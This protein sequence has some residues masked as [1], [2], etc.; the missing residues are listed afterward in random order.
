M[1]IL[2]LV[3][4]PHVHVTPITYYKFIICTCTCTLR[5]GVRAVVAPSKKAA[6]DLW[7]F[8]Y[9]II[10]IVV[11]ALCAR[12]AIPFAACATAR[13]K[14]I[15]RGEE[16]FHETSYKTNQLRGGFV[17]LF[18]SRIGD[19]LPTLQTNFIS[20]FFYSSLIIVQRLFV[21]H[22]RNYTPT[23]RTLSQMTPHIS[24]STLSYT[25]VFVDL[26][27]EYHR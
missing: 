20:V 16:S 12:R 15:V 1:Y 26:N 4:P 9:Y 25:Q 7:L 10:I 27:D 8:L 14:T 24:F 3:L 11:R 2:R 17:F 18:L 5:T 19:Y 23:P 13:L 6:S 22:F 21:D